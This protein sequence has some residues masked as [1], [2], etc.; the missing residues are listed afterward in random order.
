MIYQSNLPQPDLSPYFYDLD[1]RVRPWSLGHSVPSDATYEP[2]CCF[3]TFDEG[4]ILMECAR[5]IGGDWLD[6]GARVGWS[7]AHI[8]MAGVKSVGGIDPCFAN[9]M[10]LSK[11]LGQ[12]SCREHTGPPPKV[13][14]GAYYHRATMHSSPPIPYTFE[15][16]LKAEWNPSFYNKTLYDGFMIDGNHDSPFPLNDAKNAA[17]HLKETGVI[18]FH[19][20][21]G[22]P[23]REGVE[24]LMD[25]G[26]ACRIYNTPNGM[27]VC[28]R[29]N[30]QPPD[31]VADPAIDWKRVRRGRAPEFDF[32]RCV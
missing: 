4:A 22:R 10:M 26:F 27:A 12:A 30:F 19:D 2:E 21:W 29:R 24:H 7:T 32:A 3:M 14:C 5:R 31:H 20:F 23:I 28:W 6:V 25:N 16:V 11:F 8:T 13:N 18:I 9:E 17:A 15:E 1:I